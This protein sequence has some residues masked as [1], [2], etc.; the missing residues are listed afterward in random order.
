MFFC[1]Y[2]T[3]AVLLKALKKSDLK[4]K[5]ESEAKELLYKCC[6]EY[7]NYAL[8]MVLSE[9][10]RALKKIITPDHVISANQDQEVLIAKQMELIREAKELTDV[11][12]IYIIQ[13]MHQD[14]MQT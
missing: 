1:L 14:K 10:K 9:S 11:F 5:I 8:Q 3:Q 7:T 12:S 2:L 6:Q 4:V 13:K